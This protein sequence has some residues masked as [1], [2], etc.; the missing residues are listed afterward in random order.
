MAR[1]TD[2]GRNPVVRE[3][4]EADRIAALPASIQ[5]HHPSAADASML[6]YNDTRGALPEYS[7][8]LPFTCRRCGKQ[9]IWSGTTKRRGKRTCD[10]RTVGCHACRTSGRG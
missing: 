10:A 9:E 1:G 2:T 3:I 4:V 6:D 5:K 8:D 7:I